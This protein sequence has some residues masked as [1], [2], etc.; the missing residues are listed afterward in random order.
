MQITIKRAIS[1][2]VLIVYSCG[3]IA[4]NNNHDSTN[5][6]KSSSFK[7]RSLIAPVLL[8]GY[9]VAG[10]ESKDIKRFNIEIRDDVVRNVHGKI[11]IDDYTQFVPA[12]SVYALNIC[13]IK[14]KNNFIK[15]SVLLASSYLIAEATVFSLKYS[16]HVL[17]P[18]SSTFNSFPS[19]HTASAFVGAEF[20]W[21]EY[22]DV[23]VWYGIAAYVVATA[24]GVLRMYNNRHWLTDVAAGAGIG[25]LSTKIVYWVSPYIKK[26]FFKEKDMHTTTSIVPFYNGKQMGGSVSITF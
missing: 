23:S 7:F 9:G 6:D 19:G 10:F 16:T 20:L 12:L 18:D 1:F 14:G 8:I 26:K 4:Q 5:S 21:Q 24:T 17:R 22:K 25:I 2:L 13:G 11:K 3:I 15:R